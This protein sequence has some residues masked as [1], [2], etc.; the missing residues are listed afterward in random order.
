MQGLYD[1]P[2]LLTEALGNESWNSLRETAHK[3]KSSTAY[4]SLP[5]L[6]ELLHELE[7]LAQSA[8]AG[9]DSRMSVL[10]AEIADYV[11]AVLPAVQSKIASL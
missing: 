8:E 1:Y 10:V 5:E 2:T 6:D 4:L 3:F 9:S 11:S 7:L